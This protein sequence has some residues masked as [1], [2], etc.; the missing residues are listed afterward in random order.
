MRTWFATP[1]APSSGTGPSA[2]SAMPHSECPF[3]QNAGQP[4][5]SPECLY[6]ANSLPGVE[7]DH[8][9][10]YSQSIA[11]LAFCIQCMHHRIQVDE[12]VV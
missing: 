5:A 10:S 1:A 9:T 7:K 3:V 6:C 12:S 11:C 4:S 8:S 2:T